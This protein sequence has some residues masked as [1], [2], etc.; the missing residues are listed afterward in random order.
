MMRKMVAC[1]LVW[2]VILPVSAAHEKKILVH[3]TPAGEEDLGSQEIIE[4]GS[5]ILNKSLT[6]PPIYVS[7]VTHNEE[8][9]S[10]LYPDFVDNETA[11]WKHRKA[12]IDFAMMLSDEGVKYNFQSDWNFLLAATLY[13]AGDADTNGKNIIRFL[14]EDVGV[15]IDPHAHETQ[16]NYADV[17]YLIESL[18]V[19]PSHIVGGFIAYPPEDAKTEYF[20][21][22]LTGWVYPGYQWQADVLWGGATSLHQNEEHLWISGIWKPKDN[23]NFLV[24]DDQAPLPH[25]GNYQLKHGFQGVQDLLQKQQQGELEAGK[26]YTQTVFVGQNKLVNQQYIHEVQQQIQNLSAYT[27]AGLIQWVGL[28]ELIDIWVTEYNAEPNIY[29][30]QNLSV[31]IEK[32]KQGYLYLYDTEITALNAEQTVVIGPIEIRVSTN[33]E[34]VAFLVDDE[35]KYTDEEAPYYYRWD[36]ITC[37]THTVKVNAST[38]YGNHISDEMML[39]KLF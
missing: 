23:D 38:P 7:V 9:L 26:I 20:R 12:V 17:A 39:F 10:G 4:P 8:P 25:I 13:D 3:F 19:T 34:S 14:K 30:Y 16:Y 5:G 36:E 35:L 33:A 2:L 22:P 24:H 28:A 6:S 1:I 21:E 31:Q 32:P 15:E 37:G 18:G 27:S 11:F 29:P